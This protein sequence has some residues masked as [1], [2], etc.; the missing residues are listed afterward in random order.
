[1]KTTRPAVVDINAGDWEG[2]VSRSE[3][4]CGRTSG[5]MV[6]RRERS[7]R[8]IVCCQPTLR[9]TQSEWGGKR[10]TEGG[11]VVRLDETRTRTSV[12]VGYGNRGEGLHT[13]G[14]GQV[15]ANRINGTNIPSQRIYNH[16]G[17]VRGSSPA[18][19][20]YGGVGTKSVDN[21]CL[22]GLSGTRQVRTPLLLQI[23]H[24][25][26]V[27]QRCCYTF[28]IHRGFISRFR[29]LLPQYAFHPTCCSLS[30]LPKTS[31]SMFC[32][33]SSIAAWMRVSDA[34][35]ILTANNPAFV[36]LLIATVA[37]GTPR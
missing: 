37:T 29:S 25:L 2:C 32:M 20:F 15:G 12:Q 4:V 13:R 8:D 23:R 21:T 36:E 31:F 1:M 30:T 35:R 3:R 9:A 14:Q 11:R 18:F 17:W 26:S 19:T 34:P 22:F 7:S 33:Y 24:H 28:G 27:N 5:D 10:A 6:N 16:R